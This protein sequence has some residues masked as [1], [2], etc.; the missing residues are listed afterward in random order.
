LLRRVDG[1]DALD[2]VGVGVDLVITDVNMPNMSGLELLAQ[3]RMRR[4]PGSCP[5]WC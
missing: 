2:K 3:L 5:S 1:T 4:T